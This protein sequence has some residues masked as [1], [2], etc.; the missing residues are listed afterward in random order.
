MPCTDP[1]AVEG[2]LQATNALLEPAV[3]H[4]A[5]LGLRLL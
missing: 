1:A 3:A 5:G 2:R 4:E